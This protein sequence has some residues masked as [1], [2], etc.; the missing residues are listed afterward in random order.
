MNQP[1]SHFFAYLN[2]MRFIERWGL[3]Y[4][5]HTENIQEHSHQVAAIAHI[6][7]ILRNKRFGGNLNVERCVVLALYHDMS[8]VIT[9]DLPTPIKYFSPEIKKAYKEIEE[10]AHNRLLS[11]L[12]ADLQSDFQSIFSP[13]PADDAHWEIVKAAD[14]I[15]AYVKCQEE[16]KTG[17]QEFSHAAEVI[18]ETIQ[19]LGMPEVDYFMEVF[20][21]S[22]ILNL[23]ELK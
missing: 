11:F 2:R 10:V 6:L 12:P 21:P 1:Q 19:S 3:M 23:D 4:N 9:G 15:S 7:A 20:A 18:H 22:V 8:E 16:L 17:N 13:I 5:I 14:K